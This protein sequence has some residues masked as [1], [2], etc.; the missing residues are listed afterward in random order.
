[1]EHKHRRCGRDACSLSRRDNC[2]SVISP[3]GKTLDQLADGN[4]LGRNCHLWPSAIGNPKTEILLKGA[5]K[6]YVVV[7]LQLISERAN[8]HRDS[9]LYGD[10]VLMK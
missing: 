1:M 6:V 7:G 2:V 3:A 8:P 9:P 10:V 4:R 5:V